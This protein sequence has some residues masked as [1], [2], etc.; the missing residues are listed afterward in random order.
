MWLLSNFSSSSSKYRGRRRQWRMELQV[1]NLL[2][3]VVVAFKFTALWLEYCSMCCNPWNLLHS[4]LA[5]FPSRFNHKFNV[6]RQCITFRGQPVHY[7][8]IFRLIQHYQ[9]KNSIG[10][11]IFF[12]TRRFTPWYEYFF[13]HELWNECLTVLWQFTSQRAEHVWTYTAFVSDNWHVGG[14]VIAI[15]K[16]PEENNGEFGYSKMVGKRIEYGNSFI[17]YK[18]Y[19]LSNKQMYK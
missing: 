19:I 18:T 1:F 16:A 15:W 14:N 2:M 4:I 10:I 17:S 12:S 8:T 13:L 6:N 7:S 3:V 9:T 11:N 5:R